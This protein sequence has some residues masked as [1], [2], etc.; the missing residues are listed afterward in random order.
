MRLG[1]VVCVHP[2]C[3]D[4]PQRMVITHLVAV[5][6]LVYMRE[7]QEV[8]Y[9]EG[10]TTIFHIY[11]LF[12]MWQMSRYSLRQHYISTSSQIEEKKKTKGKEERE[13]GS[14]AGQLTK[15]LIK[16]DI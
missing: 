9:H 13:V 8:S 7:R 3:K 2:I 12:S 5:T 16:T 1:L 6:K 15:K 4:D 11:L 14:R 10:T